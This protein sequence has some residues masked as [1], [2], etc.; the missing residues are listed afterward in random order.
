[1]LKS[2]LW[3]VKMKIKLGN[4]FSPILTE[5]NNKHLGNTYFISITTSVKYHYHPH[6]AGKEKV[7]LPEGHLASKTEPG[8]ELW[9][10]GE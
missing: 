4:K 5:D 1:M 7:T 9:Q 8:F 10:S 6:L 3:K 2:I